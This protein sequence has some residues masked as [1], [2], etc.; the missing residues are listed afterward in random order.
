V[1]LLAPPGLVVRIGSSS[2]LCIPWGMIARLRRLSPSDCRHFSCSTH[3]WRQRCQE[4]RQPRRW[5]QRP[6]R[7]LWRWWWV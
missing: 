7:R 1:F 4:S 2:T 3:W 6:A 5:P